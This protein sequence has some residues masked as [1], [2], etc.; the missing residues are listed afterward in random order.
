MTLQLD[1]LFCDVTKYF[2]SFIDIEI[3]DIAFPHME[4]RNMLQIR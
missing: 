2:F 4:E 3:W 1:Y